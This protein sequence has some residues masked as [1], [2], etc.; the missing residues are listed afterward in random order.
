MRITKQKKA[1]RLYYYDL[2]MGTCLEVNW[3]EIQIRTNLDM[4]EDEECNE[5][6][7]NETN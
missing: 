1:Y 2:K 3:D 7:S 6:Q 5:K 4:L